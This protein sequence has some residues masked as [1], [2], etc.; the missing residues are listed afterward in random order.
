LEDW[1]IGGLEDWRIGG[2]VDWR[3]LIVD[4][5]MSIPNPTQGENTP[6][7]RPARPSP[8][9]VKSPKSPPATRK[10]ARSK[11]NLDSPTN[12]NNTSTTTTTTTTTTTSTTPAS[13][14]GTNSVPAA[15]GTDGEA[16]TD[17]AAAGPGPAGTEIETFLPEQPQHWSRKLVEQVQEAVRYIISLSYTVKHLRH[18]LSNL[19]QWPSVWQRKEFVGLTWYAQFFFFNSRRLF[20]HAIFLRWRKEFKGSRTSDLRFFFDRA[21]FFF[22]GFHQCFFFSPN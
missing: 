8:S 22:P 11:K 19:L 21:Q 7:A 6:A 5:V 12:P 3:F 17:S 13:P 10:L 9:K 4:K 2:L 20:I 15:G 14:T 18:R 1:R 16:V